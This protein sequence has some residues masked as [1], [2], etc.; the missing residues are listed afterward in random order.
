MV[1]QRAGPRRRR[2]LGARRGAADRRPG[3]QPAPGRAAR[4]AGPPL[5]RA[6]GRRRRRRRGGRADAR[7]R[8]TRP[9][10]CEAL[11]ELSSEEPVVMPDFAAARPASPT[12]PSTRRSSPPRARG[13]APRSPPPSGCS[14]APASPTPSAAR[15]ATTPAPPSSPATATSTTPPRRC[16]ALRGR[17]EAGRDHRPRPPLPERD[18]GAGRAD[19]PRRRPALAARLA[20]HQRLPPG[21][22]AAAAWPA[23]APSPSPRA[24][25]KTTY[26][27]GGRALDPRP[28]RDRRGRWSSRSATTPSPATRTA[29]GASSRRSSP[30]SAACWPRSGLPVCVIQEGGYALDDARRLQPRLRHRPAGGR[31]AR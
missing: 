8:C 29:A 26:L 31:G 2:L 14:T 27:R 1:E 11:G 17:P 10:T 25:T 18:L 9:G 5:R 3:L 21:T 30:R 16:A 6:A 7:R 15:P 23:N 22:R 12:S 28:L 4:R 13:S 24:P 20:G 19:G